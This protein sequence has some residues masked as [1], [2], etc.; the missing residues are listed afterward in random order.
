MLRVILFPASAAV[1]VIVR[2]PTVGIIVRLP[3]VGVIIRL[4]AVGVIVRLAAVGAIVRLPVVH[5]ESIPAVKEKIAQTKNIFFIVNL[6]LSTDDWISQ[7]V[8][9]GTIITVNTLY[10]MCGLA[11]SGKTT[12]AKV[13]V[14]RLHCH[15]IS[16]D[17]INAERG[18]GHGGDGIPIAEW[19]NTH[20]IAMEKMT[21]WMK[22]GQDIVLDDTSNLRWLRNRYRTFSGQHGYKTRL[23][24][25][26]VPVEL[27][28]QWMQANLAANERHGIRPD[29]FSEHLRTFEPPQPDEDTLVYRPEQ[30]LH[31]W[32]KKQ[33]S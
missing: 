16:L 18:L 33:F 5:A 7:F 30:E 27:I 3:V 20:H 31:N 12:L 6:L 8:P 10:L 13:I 19:E 21:G 29:I 1:S 15:C 4:P 26:D 23:I 28:R 17:E 9:E 14:D 22:S 25:S 11:F 32:V 24:Y 2:L